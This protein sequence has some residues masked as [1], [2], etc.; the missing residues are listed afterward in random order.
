M[1][2]TKFEKVGF[3]WQPKSVTAASL[4]NG[5]GSSTDHMANVATATHSFWSIAAFPGSIV[6]DPK[7]NINNLSYTGDSTIHKRQDKTVV[8]KGGILPTVSFS[9]YCTPTVLA[10]LLIG[11]L[12]GVGEAASADYGKT[13]SPASGVLD[14]TD[15]EGYLFS[16]AG[17]T[18]GATNDGFI[19]QNAIVNSLT[20]TIPNSGQG[21][22]RYARFDVEFIG[23]TLL[24][25]QN[26]TGAFSALETDIINRGVAAQK[27]DLDLTLGATNLTDLCWRNYTYTVNN[28][29]YSNCFT[30]MTANNFRRRPEIT[31]SLDIIYSDS[32]LISATAFQDGDNVAFTL[33]NQVTTTSDGYVRFGATYG[34]ITSP[35]KTSV[36]DEL[37]INLTFQ[38]EEASSGTA[39]E[40]IS[41]TDGVDW[42][43]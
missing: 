30:G 16:V 5:G 17:F 19:L 14:Y 3:V 42:G 28:N 10:G 25:E 21:E 4:P 31:H 40:G 36:D 32:T 27:F 33:T 26:M 12:Q 15:N 18:A 11:A 23:I 41:V 2:N 22:A 43:L 29:V 6:V 8:D 39:W 9:G 24:L 38:E 13:M 37:A 20:V 35:V 34:T 7:V 1:F